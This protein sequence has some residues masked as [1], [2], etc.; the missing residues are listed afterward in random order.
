MRY[1]YPRLHKVVAAPNIMGPLSGHKT[2]SEC[3]YDSLQAL[4][5]V[6]SP[7][8]MTTTNG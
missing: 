1:Q 2:M 3:H 7:H 4:F 5:F 6:S 8:A